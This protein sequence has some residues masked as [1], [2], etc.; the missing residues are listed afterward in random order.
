MHQLLKGLIFLLAC[1]LL[2]YSQQSNYIKNNSI[3]VDYSFSFQGTQKSTL[4]DYDMV[5]IDGL[6]QFGVVGSPRLPVKTIRI[7]IPFGYKFTGISA[8]GVSRKLNGTC[9]IVPVQKPIRPGA[10]FSKTISKN[11]KVYAM[12]TPYPANP[13]PDPMVYRLKGFSILTA[14]LYPIQYIP[15]TGEA[16]FYQDITVTVKLEKGSSDINSLYRGLPGDISEVARLVDNPKIVETYPSRLASKG[17]YDLLVIT[18][19]TMQSQFQ[20][21]ADWKNLI[22]TKTEIAL[23]SD[24]LSSSTGRDDPDKIRNFIKDEYSNNGIDFV[25]IG[26]DVDVIPKRGMYDNS[27]ESNNFPSTMYWSCLDGTYD[28][29]NDQKYAEWLEDDVDYLAEVFVGRIPVET[30]QEATG[31]INKIISFESSP[32][33][34]DIALHGSMFDMMGNGGL[35]NSAKEIKEGNSVTNNIGCHDYIPNDYTVHTL[36]EPDEKP[37]KSQ[38]IDL[39]NKDVLIFNHGGHGMETYYSVSY[40]GDGFGNSDAQALTNNVYPIHASGSCLT[41]YFDYDQ[42]DCLAENLI[43]NPNGGAIATLLNARFGLYSGSNACELSGELDIEFFRLC[44]E[45]SVSTLG[46]AAQYA[47]QCF[48]ADAERSSGYHFVL[49]EWNLLG[50]PS[51]SIT[52][53]SVGTITNKPKLQ[54]TKSRIFLNGNHLQLHE[55]VLVGDKLSVI[56]I[57]GRIIFTLIINSSANNITLPL[58]SSGIYVLKNMRKG[59]EVW[60]AKVMK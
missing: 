57:K 36:Y 30:A 43:L 44:F 10:K 55:N 59:K 20:K 14:N 56:D 22:G 35:G 6:R 26:G 1:S 42:E 27:P 18:N 33:P 47:R 8:Q 48:A 29:D 58:F 11:D 40:S 7:L 32:R 39:W 23:I 21:L 4:G 46:Q 16:L 54:Q 34:K 51:L 15:S 12:S 53:Q 49:L 45:D 31:V 17:D 50:D 52:E 24:I 3:A 37:T 13:C 2:I 41:G 19:S 28:G 9:S 60:R 38:F 5:M 25:I